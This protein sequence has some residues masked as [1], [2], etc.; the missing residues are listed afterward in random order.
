MNKLKVH[1]DPKV[2]VVFNNYPKNVQNKIAHIR[3]LI[4]EVAQET[5][6]IDELEETLKWGEP[7]YIT[8]KGSTLRIA[9]KKKTPDQYGMYFQCTSKLV[10]SFKVAY[11]SV[12]TFEGT[13]A[14]IFKLNE[15]IPQIELKRC[16][17]TALTYHTKKH[18]PLLGL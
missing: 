1:S 2:E 17:A 9:W 7:S 12:F 6:S 15:E 5:I 8:K 18:L 13:R 11:K 14:I 4:L 10:A 16:I 3:N